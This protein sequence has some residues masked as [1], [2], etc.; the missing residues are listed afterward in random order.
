MN[1]LQASPEFVKGANAS[2]RIV[3]PFLGQKDVLLHAKI[4]RTVNSCVDLASSTAQLWVASPNIVF[5]TQ[6]IAFYSTMGDDGFLSYI[7][8]TKEIP[9]DLNTSVDDWCD[10]NLTAADVGQERIESSLR[11][12]VL[13]LHFHD[14]QID[15]VF[16]NIGFDLFV[17][18]YT[19]PTVK[20]FALGALFPGLELVSSEATVADSRPEIVVEKRVQEKGI[21]YLIGCEKAQ[22]LKIGYTKN[23][24][25][26]LKS[27][28]CSN[29][30]ELKLID[31]KPGTIELEQTLLHKF[32]HL[33][34]RGEWFK[35]DK[36]ILRAFNQD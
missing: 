17:S 36:S 8:V 12:W 24:N 25:Q 6:F 28:Q 19:T 18:P 7:H 26:R 9:K 31:S 16:A 33:K 13:N 23:L 22:A 32:S 20:L 27:L 1:I 35:W 4:V 3:I 5:N 10:E 21:V 14:E 11:D 30:H 34:L 2:E 29:P 15:K